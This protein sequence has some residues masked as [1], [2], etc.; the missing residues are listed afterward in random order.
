VV[1]DGFADERAAGI[2]GAEEED[3]HGVA[4]GWSVCVLVW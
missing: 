4:F 1:E 3:V 2:A